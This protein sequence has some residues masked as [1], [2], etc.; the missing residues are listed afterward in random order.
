[1]LTTDRAVLIRYVRDGEAR[2]GSGLRVAGQF[3][4]T[5]DHC[6]DGTDHILVAD[7]IEYPAE[8]FARSGDADV[9]MAI[10]I[11]PTLPAVGPLGCAVID[12]RVPREVKDCRA[13]GFP[14]W[15]DSPR[16]PRL[17]QVPGVIPTAEGVDPQAKSIVVAPMSLKITNPDIREHKVPEGELDRTGSPWAGMSGAVV[18]TADELVVGV[19]R[20]HSPAEGVGSLTA[21]RIEALQSLPSDV[22]RLFLSALRM[23]DLEEWPRVPVE[24]SK[25]EKLSGK[26]ERER[27]LGPAELAVLRPRVAAERVARMP[28]DEVVFLLATAPVGVS[29]R[30]LDVLLSRDQSR[31]ISLL[32]DMDQEKAE[33]L[34]A[35]MAFAPDWLKEL[36]IAVGAIADREDDLRLRAELG[37]DVG[38][39]ARAVPSWRATEGYYKSYENGQIHWSARSGAQAT[40]GAIADCYVASA[41]SGGRLGFPLTSDVKAGT[42]PFGTD[43]SLQ[44]FEG[45]RDYSPDVCERIGS[46]GASV[47]SSSKYG[48]HLVWGEIGEFY[49]LARGT[50]GWLGFP[51]SDP[52]EVGPS[53]RTG[54]G[55]TGWCQRFE[56]GVVYYSEKTQAFALSSVMAAYHDSRGGVVSSRGFPVSP[57]LTA[58]ESS[59]GTAGCFQRFE[60]RKDYPEDI[61][62]HWSREEGP[63]NAT[64]YTSEAYGTYTVGWGNGVLYER[65]GGTGSWL[66]FPKSD[67]IDPRASKKE[68]YRTVQEFEGGVIFF[69]VNYGSI[70]VARAIVDYISEHD[71]VERLGF[72]IGPEKQVGSSGDDK[73]Q[74][75]EDGVVTVQK[76]LIS[77]WM[78]P[79]ERHDFAVD[80][81]TTLLPDGRLTAGDALHA[82]AHDGTVIFAIRRDGNLVASYR[83]SISG[84]WQT[85]WDSQTSTAKYL[86]FREDGNMVL[87]TADDTVLIDWH[88]EGMGGNRLEVQGDGNVVL[89]TN[90]DRPVWA[91]DR[92]KDGTIVPPAPPGTRTHPKRRMASPS[93][94]VQWVDL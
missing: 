87:C 59:Y 79:G 94:Q 22:A 42:S 73:I 67:E 77:A 35:A 23:P 4:L 62:K 74:F 28:D 12:R 84:Q 61:L 54:G 46:C 47:Y 78:R 37:T 90:E 52:F 16:G 70:T 17:A 1:V 5:A 76:S 21:T 44:R 83:E 66:G 40:R 36:P 58:A 41:G 69:R 64:I 89:Y 32:A 30:V 45:E 18:V 48:P 68:T 19:I 49:E 50:R 33:E 86:A 3:V 72:P 82:D 57:E 7:G 6:A 51:T 53:Q 38:G 15:K 39:L 25:A 81:G 2:R 20:A 88:A 10:L 9:D 27:P 14:V 80:R 75:F 43:G 56:G 31:T 63:G 8:V 55:T 91:T 92:L 29:A 11:G 65:L 93:G 13:L 24:V 60:G 34:I 71:L 26:P 85:L